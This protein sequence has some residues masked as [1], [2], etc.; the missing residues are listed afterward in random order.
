M[1]RASAEKKRACKARE[2]HGKGFADLRHC[3]LGV[4]CYA[5]SILFGSLADIK[6]PFI[7]FM[8]EN[9][10]R[11][12]GAAK[13]LCCSLRREKL[14][15]QAT[16]YHTSP[17]WRTFFRSQDSFKVF[18]KYSKMGRIKPISTVA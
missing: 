12:V 3:E 5:R 18:A 1:K 16:D 14:N 11:G 8:F 17:S 2:G 7:M 6:N 15:L 9:A 10:R 4:K 13:T